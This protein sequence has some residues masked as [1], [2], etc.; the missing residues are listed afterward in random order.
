MTDTYSVEAA[1]AIICGS[2]EA[3]PAQVKWLTRR[4]RG[5]ATPQLPGYKA[6]RRWRMTGDDITAAIDLLPPRRVPTVPAASS[7]TRTSA[8]RLAS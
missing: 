3:T 4:L 2:T 6:Q 5:E 1:A 7:M 8:R